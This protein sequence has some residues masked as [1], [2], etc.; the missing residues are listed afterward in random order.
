M[1]SWELPVSVIFIYA[2]AL[3]AGSTCNGTVA[4][5]G[6]MLT[7][8]VLRAVCAALTVSANAFCEHGESC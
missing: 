8:H 3:V 5:S 7:P 1:F 4:P 6:A 2:C